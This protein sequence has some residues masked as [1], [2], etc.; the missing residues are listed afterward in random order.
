M[1][2]PGTDPDNVRMEDV[3]CDFCHRQWSADLPLIEGHQGSCLCGRCLSVAY[4][5]V[6][7]RNIG[8]APAGYHCTMCLESGFDR[9]ALG[10]ADEP[11][12]QS[13]AHPDACICR[14][15]IE[16]AAKALEKDPDFTWRRPA[17]SPGP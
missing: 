11:G 10:R 6:V 8:S 5:E 16:L 13:P 7:L 17:L 2:R 9:E 3:L 4:A 12:W 15:C 14:R 1:R